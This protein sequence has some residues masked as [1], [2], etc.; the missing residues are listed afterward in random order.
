MTAKKLYGG[1]WRLL[2]SLGEGGQGDVFRVEDANCEWPDQYAL[3]RVRS[4]RR[5][6]RFRHEVEAIKTLDHPNVIKL[7]DHSAL[8]DQ[9]TA[10][11]RQ[12]LIMPIAKGGDLSKPGRRKLYES[13]LH[14]VLRGC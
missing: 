8:D 1:R 9:G 7:I 3:K 5:Y 6:K 4:P 14:A 11:D 13:D 10:A 12:F 2:E